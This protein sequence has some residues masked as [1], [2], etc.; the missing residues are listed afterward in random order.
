MSKTGSTLF[1]GY[2]PKVKKVCFPTPF[3]LYSLEQHRERGLSNQMI[4]ALQLDS[5]EQNKKRKR[6]NELCARKRNKLISEW[7]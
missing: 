6:S 1:F 4:L 3:F 7:P 5:K 2:S